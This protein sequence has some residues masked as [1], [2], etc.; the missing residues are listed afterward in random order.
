MCF[1][2][3]FHSETEFNENHD[4]IIPA[5]CRFFCRPGTIFNMR[6]TRSYQRQF[7]W[8]KRLPGMI[9]ISEIHIIFFNA[10]L[11]VT[12]FVNTSQVRI[13]KIPERERGQYHGG[14]SCEPFVNLPV[15]FRQFYT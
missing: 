8:Y 13:F 10:V 3:Y 4:H 14:K 15:I 1:V 7:V 2:S 12:D 6:A 9:F 11:F 5:G